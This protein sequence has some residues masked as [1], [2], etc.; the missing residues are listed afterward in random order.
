MISKKGLIH[1]QKGE[2]I[3]PLK[4][5]KGTPLFIDLTSHELNDKEIEEMAEE[6]KNAFAREIAKSEKI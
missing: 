2:Y 3:V 4:T 5:S 6:I 1:L